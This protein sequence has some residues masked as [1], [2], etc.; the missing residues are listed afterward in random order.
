MV[1]PTFKAGI[2][3]EVITGMKF[4]VYI[5]YSNNGLYEDEL[6][7]SPIFILQKLDDYDWC[8]D[9]EIAQADDVEKY[10]EQDLNNFKNQLKNIKQKAYE[11]YENASLK[12]NYSNNARVK[13]LVKSFRRSK[14]R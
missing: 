10:L 2:Y 1:Q 8:S 11:Y 5:I 12:N 14:R 7:P 6:P 4:P 13:S 9:W 3:K